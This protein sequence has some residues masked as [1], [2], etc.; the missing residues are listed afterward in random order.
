[1]LASLVNVPLPDQ[2]GDYVSVGFIQHPNNVR[3]GQFVIHEQVANR[4][5]ALGILVMRI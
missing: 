3:D 1:M 5:L 4:H 2:D